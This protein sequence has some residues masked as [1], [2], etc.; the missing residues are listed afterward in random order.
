MRR[1]DELE[2][3]EGAYDKM[4]ELVE[5]MLFRFTA[6]SERSRSARTT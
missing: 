3:G 1:A 2:T 5:R 6:L 4:V